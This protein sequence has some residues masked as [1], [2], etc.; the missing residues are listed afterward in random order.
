MIILI[1]I[2]AASLIAGIA[3]GCSIGETTPQDAANDRGMYASVTYYAA[4]GKFSQSALCYKTIYFE[5]GKPIYYI[6]EDTA[7]VGS[8][9]IT[10]SRTNKIFDGWVKAE[11]DENGLPI[12]LEMT[13][14]GEITD[15]VLQM[16]DNGSALI[17]GDDGKE[18]NEQ[19]KLFTAK[20]PENPAADD[21]V[22][23]NGK[24]P[25][26]ANGE[27][28]YLV[29]TW[30]NDVVLD[31]VLVADE[32][33]T[34]Q[35]PKADDPATEEDESKT[36]EDKVVAP[37]EIIK[38]DTFGRAGTITLKPTT[39]PAT[40]AGTSEYSYIFLF[41]DE[42]C[43]KP[44]TSVNGNKIDRPQDGV[45]ATIYAKY[46]KG[47]WTA[48]SDSL[49]VGNMLSNLGAT[50]YYFVDDIDCSK[51]SVTLNSTDTFTGTILGN[52]YKIFNIT[53]GSSRYPASLNNE[54]TSSLLGSLG[55]TAVIKDFTIE[56]VT[57]YASIR[58]PLTGTTTASIYALFSGYE[59]GATLEKFS[60]NG[61]KLNV[62]SPENTRI[63]NMSTN[64]GYE[65]THWLYGGDS[66][67]DFISE[68]GEI[69]KNPALTINNNL[70]IGQEESNE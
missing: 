58:S 40:L 62:S 46:L 48:V 4:G 16:H 50:S 20:I 26:L 1:A 52:G 36:M 60:V 44:V 8:S 56:N 55:A 53:I 5:P 19:Q 31:Y 15:N 68:Y 66:D 39:A 17:V 10:I 49:G 29:A 27:H 32:A 14:S 21:Y 22:F 18:L 12:L 61:Y 45:N 23:E 38:S 67:A 59:E 70:I 41:W 63:G 51:L 43:T 28:L 37:G 13:E 47:D 6:G 3:A 2:F 69:I 11:V 7:P 54:S 64:D 33:V 57:V 30:K 42:E 34:F 25:T 24:R 65:T 9:A 35:V